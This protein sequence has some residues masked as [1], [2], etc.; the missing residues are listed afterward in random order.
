MLFNLFSSQ[1]SKQGEVSLLETFQMMH[2]LS[3]HENVKRLAIVSDSI[4]WQQA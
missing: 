4:G 3:Q 2:D 1:L